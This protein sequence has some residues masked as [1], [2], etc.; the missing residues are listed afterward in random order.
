MNR[1]SRTGDRL[2]PEHIAP[3]GGICPGPVCVPM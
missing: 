2:C 1:R 3:R